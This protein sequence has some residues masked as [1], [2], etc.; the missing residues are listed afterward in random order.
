[1]GGAKTFKVN[2]KLLAFLNNCEGEMFD[3]IDRNI[4]ILDL[5]WS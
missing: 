3:L 4:R 5:D 2:L 1:M